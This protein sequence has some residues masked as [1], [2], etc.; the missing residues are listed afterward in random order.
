[1]STDDFDPDSAQEIICEK[2]WSFVGEIRSRSTL[3]DPV[4]ESEAQLYYLETYVW[5]LVTLTSAATYHAKRVSAEIEQALSYLGSPQAIAQL[6]RQGND[7]DDIVR[8]LWESFEKQSKLIIRIGSPPKSLVTKVRKSIDSGPVLF[9][10][11]AFLVSTRSALDC[12][13]RVLGVYIKGTDFRSIHK[14]YK[15]LKKNHPQADVTQFVSREWKRWIE[16]LKAYRDAVTHNI[17]LNFT[18]SR[19]Q[20]FEHIGTPNGATKHPISDDIFLGF[21]IYRTPPKFHYKVFGMEDVFD[22]ELPVI[23]TSVGLT[24]ELPDGTNTVIRRT[25]KRLDTTIVMP[26][27]QYLAET[28]QNMQQFVTEMFALLEEQRGQFFV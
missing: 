27:E 16:L 12:A 9:E 25:T 7:I 10:F 17:V 2:A 6:R 3:H 18:A 23:E 15:S 26:L 21:Y 1:M 11:N 22:Q 24:V 8:A 5:N 14:L 28:L 4:F 13:A 19:E 20:S